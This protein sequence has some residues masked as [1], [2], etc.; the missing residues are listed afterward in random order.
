MENVV[1]SCLQR[2]SGEQATVSPEDP[3]GASPAATPSNQ[4]PA[5]VGV[6][7]AQRG[8]DLRQTQVLLK[9]LCEMRV[10]LCDGAPRM[11]ASA[12]ASRHLATMALW[13]NRARDLFTE[14]AVEQGIEER[15]DAGFRHAHNGRVR[16][17]AGEFKRAYLLLCCVLSDARDTARHGPRPYTVQTGRT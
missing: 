16:E 4:V 2:G 1:F 12:L 6:A 5:S 14:S 9:A 13:R 3:H 7:H 17:A 11:P 15:L 8:H 10:E